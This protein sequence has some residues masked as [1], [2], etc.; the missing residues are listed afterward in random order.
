MT[1]IAEDITKLIAGCPPDRDD[2]YESKSAA[3]PL[4]ATKQSRAVLGPDVRPEDRP[5]LLWLFGICAARGDS[6]PL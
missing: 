2:F 5:A 3:Q 1:S 6:D 4:A